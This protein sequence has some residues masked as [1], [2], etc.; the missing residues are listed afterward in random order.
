MN[1]HQYDKKC[2]TLSLA[3]GVYAE[4]FRRSNWIRIDDD[5]QL[6]LA[7][8]AVDTSRLSLASKSSAASRSSG[9][10]V[11]TTDSART[12]SPRVI[13]GIRVFAFC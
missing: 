4:S 8:P 3:T 7:F 13:T 6:E 12:P 11:D 1:I 10:S 9:L 5:G 2:K